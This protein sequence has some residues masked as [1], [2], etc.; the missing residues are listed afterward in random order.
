MTISSRTRDI[1]FLSAIS[2][3]CFF[4]RLGS[5]SLFDFNEG[6]YVEAAREMFLRGDYVTPQVNGAFFFDKPPLVLWLAA[7]SFHLFGVTEFAARL[8]VAVCAT[9]LVFLTYFF[10]SRYFGRK[11]GLFAGAIIAANPLMFYRPP[12][13]HGYRAEPVLWHGDGQ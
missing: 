9:L 1:L 12:D 13:D 3:L 11:T 10:A 8:P 2:F 5:I 4:W 6:F 7:G